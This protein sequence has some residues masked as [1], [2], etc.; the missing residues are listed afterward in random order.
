MSEIKAILFDLDGTLLDSDMQVFLP[1]YLQQIA[2]RVAHLIQPKEFIAYLLAATQAMVDNDGRATNAQVFEEAF[3]P[4]VGRSQAELEPIF[5]DFYK[6]DYPAL[7]RLTAA[8]PD[9]RPTVQLAFDLGYEVVIATNPLFPEI[10]TRQ[11]MAWAGVDGFPYRRVT[12]YENSRFAKPNPRYFA[13]ILAEIGCAPAAALVVGDE[14]M[15]MVAATIGC[16]TFLVPSAATKLNGNVPEPAYRGT[17]TDVA[18]LLRA[19]ATRAGAA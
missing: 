2:A 19:I 17:L 10:A 7:Q 4:Q 3:Y 11:R 13:E 14:A 15:D 16:T 6:R 18:A 5:M 1:Q 12:T 9:A 8:K